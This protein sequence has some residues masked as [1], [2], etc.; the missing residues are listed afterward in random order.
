MNSR[1]QFEVW[2][3]E[4]VWGVQKTNGF[5]DDPRTHDAWSAWQAS[6]SAVVID[7][8]PH[9]K[10]SGIIGYDYHQG[11]KSAKETAMAAIQAA[12]LS[13]KK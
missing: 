10:D 12:G 1:E 8:R 6:R 5:Y 4:R 13:V 11:Y 7:L 3:R 9:P 2:A